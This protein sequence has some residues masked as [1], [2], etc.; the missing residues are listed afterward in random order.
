MK[1]TKIPRAAWDIIEV[2]LHDEMP[3]A[4]RFAV[5][6]ALG[7]LKWRINRYPS[8]RVTELELA[9]RKLR[10]FND[11]DTQFVL[12][13]IWV[14]GAY[15]PVA[16]LHPVSVL[17]LGANQGLSGCWF[18]NRFPDLKELV[19]YEPEPSCFAL[20]QYNLPEA[21]LHREAIGKE[22]G[23]MRLSKGN[24]VV[25][26][27]VSAEGLG[28]EVKVVAMRSLLQRRWDIVKMDIEGAEWEVFEDLLNDKRLLR[29]CGYWMVEFHEGSRSGISSSQIIEVFASIGYKNLMRGQVMH[30]YQESPSQ[31]K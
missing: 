21:V 17:D 8:Q 15:E 9:G 1:W 28:E 12:K 6:R 19:M 29:T 27:R 13:E 16:P 4:E 18:L 5:A 7:K 30:L 2:L 25:N 31:L 22:D 10:L 24:G 23:M 11:A 20:L 14:S 3:M 26:T